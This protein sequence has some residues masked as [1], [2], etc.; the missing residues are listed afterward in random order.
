MK[1]VRPQS[2]MTFRLMYKRHHELLAVVW[3][4]SWGANTQELCN[5][6]NKLQAL[7]EKCYVDSKLL[8]PTTDYI[9]SNKVPR[10]IGIAN[11]NDP[12]C[13]PAPPSTS[14]TAAGLWLPRANMLGVKQ[15]NLVSIHAS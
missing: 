5:G 2:R 4:Q 6:H 10:A 14:G 3:V 7:Y 1:E 11:R 8:T 13:T 12:L 9:R 15:L